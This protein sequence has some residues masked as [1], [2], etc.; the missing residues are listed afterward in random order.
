MVRELQLSTMEE[1][2]SVVHQRYE[3][4]AGGSL[5]IKGLGAEMAGVAALIGEHAPRQHYTDILKGVQQWERESKRTADAQRKKETAGAVRCTK[6]EKRHPTGSARMGYSKRKE[7]GRK[8][9]TTTDS[10]IDAALLD[11]IWQ[12]A[13][14]SASSECSS[15]AKTAP[16]LDANGVLSMENERREVVDVPTL[17]IFSEPPP[18]ICLPSSGDGAATTGPTPT[19]RTTTSSSPWPLYDDNDHVPASGPSGVT[20]TL[21]PSDTTVP[22]VWS[23]PHSEA[24][25]LAVH[26][27]TEVDHPFGDGRTTSTP[28]PTTSPSYRPEASPIL[29]MRRYLWR[30]EQKSPASPLPV[31]STEEEEAALGLPH[32]S[33]FY[34]R[35]A[36]GTTVEVL[37]VDAFSEEEDIESMVIRDV[38]VQEVQPSADVS[39]CY[40][41]SSISLPAEEGTHFCNGAPAEEREKRPGPQQ[42][43]SQKTRREEMKNGTEEAAKEK[44]ET[45]ERNAEV[46]H[47]T[48]GTRPHGICIPPEGPST[49]V[50]VPHTPSMIASSSPLTAEMMQA[51]EQTAWRMMLLMENDD[52]GPR[53]SPRR[54]SSSPSS[55]VLPLPVSP[56]EEGATVQQ[57][58]SPQSGGSK[59]FSCTASP[60]TFG[61]SHTGATTAQ[62]PPRPPSPLSS[63]PSPLLT[64]ISSSSPSSWCGR[65]EE[66]AHGQFFSSAS[67]LLL[68]SRHA[69]TAEEEVPPLGAVSHLTET[70]RGGCRTDEHHSS[71]SYTT[72]RSSANSSEVDEMIQ[73][74]L[75][76]HHLCSS[77]SSTSP[78]YSKEEE[79]YSDNTCRL[80]SVHLPRSTPSLSRETP[81]PLLPVN[82][83]ETCLPDVLP[84][85]GD[86]RSAMGIGEDSQPPPHQQKKEEV[87]M[88][89]EGVCK[90]AWVDVWQHDPREGIGRPNR[91]RPRNRSSQEQRKGDEAPQ[92]ISHEVDVL[93]TW[94][95]ALP[96]RDQQLSLQEDSLTM[97]R[98]SSSVRNTNASLCDGTSTEMLAQ[99]TPKRR[100]EEEGR[101]EERQELEEEKREDENSERHLKWKRE[102]GVW[103]TPYE[104]RIAVEIKR[105]VESKGIV[106]PSQGESFPANTAP[107][108]KQCHGEE[109]EDEVGRDDHLVQ[110]GPP[111]TQPCAP[112]PS[113]M[114]DNEEASEAALWHS[115]SPP[116]LGSHAATSDTVGG[117]RTT[118]RTHGG[119]GCRVLPSPPAV[120]SSHV[121]TSCQEEE[122]QQKEEEQEGCG[123]DA[124]G[125]DSFPCDASHCS[126]LSTPLLTPAPTQE[127]Q[128][129]E[130]EGGTSRS[131][132]PLSP[133]WTS[134]S[135]LSPF[136][137]SKE[138]EHEKRRDTEEALLLA[139]R[140]EVP[141]RGEEGRARALRMEERR[142]EEW[143]WMSTS[144]KTELPWDTT[145]ALAAPSLLS[146]TMTTKVCQADADR[147]TTPWR[148][149]EKTPD[150]KE[151]EQKKASCQSFSPPVPSLVREMKNDAPPSPRSLRVSPPA[152]PLSTFSTST[153]ENL[154]CFLH[155]QA[156]TSHPFRCVSSPLPASNRMPPPERTPEGQTEEERQFLREVV[157]IQETFQHAVVPFYLHRLGRYSGL[158]PYRRVTAKALLELDQRR[159]RRFSCTPWTS[160]SASLREENEEENERRRRRRAAEEVKVR[161]E[162][163]FNGVS[164]DKKEEV[165]EKSAVPSCM[166]LERLP[167][168]EEE[169]RKEE[170]NE[171][172]RCVMTAL[173]ADT[174]ERRGLGL[175]STASLKEGQ[176]SLPLP[177]P[178]LSFSSSCGSSSSTSLSDGGVGS[179]IASCASPLRNTAIWT[180][181]EE[182]LLMAPLDFAKTVAMVQ[183]E[184]PFLSTARIQG[185]LQANGVVMDMYRSSSST[186]A[187]LLS[188]HQE[189]SSSPPPP[190]PSFFSSS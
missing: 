79:G 163:I 39:V 42:T 146:H 114:R 66:M 108:R 54:P 182:L 31:S 26:N 162:A 97:E 183:K 44:N 145:T 59:G 104:R 98:F 1:L 180:P 120:C 96:D 32:T 136:A 55:S 10:L 89:R 131:P 90:E 43:F 33:L 150:P 177:S 99:S 16:S 128:D 156:S 165:R 9:T 125:V 7:A 48:G 23:A 75:E 178:F 35:A 37:D 70:Y 50:A 17:G 94:T 18:L 179:A 115:T 117:E 159:P 126:F 138:M 4:N 76:A 116:P 68:P 100:K 144:S 166:P 57:D 134:I 111:V 74:L 8:G 151:M 22:P 155:A 188:M 168:T 87:A 181:L 140:K 83:R 175:C 129:E 161:D 170:G 124:G 109:A 139:A 186:V 65:E 46:G 113:C 132:L 15:R 84:C 110:S 101:H 176:R 91:K 11:D 52:T 29:W 119:G 141:R 64:A 78:T 133:L 61:V 53:N 160:T 102:E 21:V 71:G 81:I 147:N 49:L 121:R 30:R 5:S 148:R 20:T 118:R 24:A 56:Q 93:A 157:R 107:S 152:P 153:E 92:W 137:L 171:Y 143:R 123:W 86:G 27:G 41:A 67:S 51:L 62:V 28:I 130:Q 122:Q 12:A 63:F 3:M 174:I 95:V 167:L 106:F 19:R 142:E 187:S 38:Q 135:L 190:P 173:C 14:R 154:W 60:A 184:F 77:F 82:H 72:I 40:S 149:D 73:D 2:C 112:F 105:D 69:R 13:H 25:V 80:F 36:D 6:T 185:L 47:S 88:E 169:A 103:V 164:H 158:P 127:Q 45:S 34:R 172:T 85:S 58:V 189:R